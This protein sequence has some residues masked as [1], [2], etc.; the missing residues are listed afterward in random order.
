MHETDPTNPNNPNKG[1]RSESAQRILV[2]DDDVDVSWAIAGLIEDFGHRVSVVNRAA[3]TLDRARTFHPALVL[4]DLAMPGTSGYEL[5]PLLRASPELEGARL[6]ALS[7]YDREE[8]R[9]RV[10]EA[11]FDRLWVKPIDPDALAGLL[12]ESLSAAP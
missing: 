12:Q 11:G 6:V 10:F 5:A 4:L 8:D 9:R 2:V 7:G 3:D 1:A